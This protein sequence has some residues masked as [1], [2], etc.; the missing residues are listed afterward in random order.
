MLQH[1]RS[2]HLLTS[3]FFFLSVVRLYLSL[4][5][6]LLSG[7]LVGVGFRHL[8]RVIYKPLHRDPLHR[9]YKQSYLITYHFT[10]G[11]VNL[12]SLH[13]D[14]EVLNCYWR[15]WTW[16]REEGRRRCLLVSWNTGWL[17]G[18]LRLRISPWPHQPGPQDRNTGAG[19]VDVTST[20]PVLKGT[21]GVGIFEGEL[22]TNQG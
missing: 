10:F 19:A 3:L 6:Y 17:A 11:I 22:R 12:C 20:V 13:C 14:Q 1:S 4:V 2:W 18:A 15:G 5:F 16:R 9:W 21:R 8:V 7:S